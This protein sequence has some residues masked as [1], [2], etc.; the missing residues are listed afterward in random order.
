TEAVDEESGQLSGAG[1]GEDS[2]ADEAEP[3]GGAGAP[4]STAFAVRELGA[5]ENNVELYTRLQAASAE[6][7][8]DAD[9]QSLEQDTAWNL[10][11]QEALPEA[12]GT[13]ERC[14]VGLDEADPGLSGVL[15]QATAE[16]SGTPAV[17]YVYGTV[18][19]RQRVVVVSADGCQVLAVFDL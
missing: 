11:D 8:P 4:E 12:E 9:L 7:T 5:V 18:V 19:G 10:E 6:V 16:Y 14:Q 13:S 2:T 17:V 1:S 15:L 3:A